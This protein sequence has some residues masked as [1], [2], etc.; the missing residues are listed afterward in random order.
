MSSVLG[1]SRQRPPV[2]AGMGIREFAW[3]LIGMRCLTPGT[4][5][6]DDSA[7]TH[8]PVK[9]LPGPCFWWC[10]TLC[11]QRLGQF[12]GVLFF[13]PS[14]GFLTSSNRFKAMTYRHLRS[15]TEST[16]TA[17]YADAVIVC[18]HVVP[19]CSSCPT[20]GRLTLAPLLVGAFIEEMDPF[21][22]EPR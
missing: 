22:A 21:G 5:V 20:L 10:P 9:C 8:L 16:V 11:D 3:T 14:P 6:R 12:L 18:G 1:Y 2:F 17:E 19:V 7:T 15:N 4:L 13:L